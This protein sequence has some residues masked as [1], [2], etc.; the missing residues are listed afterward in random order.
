MKAICSEIKT[1]IPFVLHNILKDQFRK[2][3]LVNSLDPDEQPY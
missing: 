2:I 3:V 1:E